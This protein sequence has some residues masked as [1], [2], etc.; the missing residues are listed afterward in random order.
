MRFL[1]FVAGGML[2]AAGCRDAVQQGGDSHPAAVSVPLSTQ[3][4]KA[5]FDATRMAW[6]ERAID[7]AIVNEDIPGAVLLVGLGDEVVYRKA[8]G[9][10]A[11]KPEKT[12]MAVDTVFD[13]ASLTKGIATATSIMLLAERGRIGLNDRVSTHIPAFG[14][15]GKKDITISQLLLHCGG[16]TPDNSRKDYTTGTRMDMLNRVFNLTPTCEPGTRFIYSDVGYIVLGELVR[17]VDGRPLDQFA[18]EEIFEPLG[19]KDT[20]FKPG[21]AIRARCASTEQRDGHWMIGEVHD[22]RA[23]GLGGVA[24]H[25]GLFSTADDLGRYCRMLLNGGTLD[26]KRVLSD[27]T[28]REMLRP[29][30]LPDGNRRTY[31]FD[32][33]TSYSSARGNLFDC[34]LTFGHTGWTGTMFWV[35]PVHDCYAILLTN[36][37]HP[38]GKGSAIDVRTRAMNV[39][40][41]AIAE[42]AGQR[43]LPGPDR[44]STSRPATS[45]PTAST[46][47]VLCGIDVLER[48][49]FKPL[50]GKRVALLTNHTGRDRRGRRTIDLLAEAKGVKLVRLLSPEHG[51]QGKADGQVGDTV[52]EKTGIRIFS[53]YGKTQRPTPE[54]L[55]DLDCIVYDIQDIGTRFYT[56]VGTLGFAMEAAAKLNLEV[57]VLDRPNPI[58]GIGVDG[59]LWDR[60]ERL[61]VGYGPLP[62]MHGMTAGELARL[63]NDEYRIKCRL[64]VVP[65]EGWRRPMLWDDTGL[66]WINPSPNMRNLTE[67]MLYPGIGLLE[68]T[69]LSVGRGT[70][71]PFETLGAPWIDG[72][73]LAAA[74][75]AADLPGLRFIPIEFT[76]QA[77]V[78]AGTA[79]QGV[80]LL[81]TDR[82]RLE[83][84]RA[85][86]TIAW[87][88]RKL[89]GPKFEIDRMATLLGNTAALDALKRAEDPRLLAE[90]WWPPLVEFRKI[91]ARYVIYGE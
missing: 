91:R 68:T 8:F 14:A 53:L 59:P 13:L 5:S 36:R 55:A 77:S 19:M 87:T 83:P 31:G 38:D 6:A 78:F 28:V 70:D 50:Q 4:S 58:G 69:N 2:L 47:E 72:P 30:C 32:V 39:V 44:V 63:F 66:T 67:A 29:R 75:N 89:S 45:R 23:Y 42:V 37:V 61:L 18:R 24:G 51:V 56:Y 62:V 34:E 12:P 1:F 60:P 26:G 27:M 88:L 46:P 52:D 76:P 43:Y 49:G 9:N 48:D 65:V 82:T 3:A 71:Q 90:K 17:I 57:V 20:G 21:E 54:M 64:T 25:A 16:L 74:L 79:C 80:H 81:V 84:V 73:A 40:A 7:D 10:R 86:L 33:N 35:D 41:G 15:A 11:L 85:G 22:P